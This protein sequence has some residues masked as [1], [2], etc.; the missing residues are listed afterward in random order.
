MSDNLS[1]YSSGKYEEGML[2]T[3]PFYEA[4]Y[5]ETTSLIGYLKPHVES[6]LDTGCG[7]GSLIARAY[8]LFRDTNFL[9]A[10]PS[11]EM[12]NKAQQTLSVIPASQL[13]IIGSI[14]TESLPELSSNNPQVITA[15]LAHHYFNKEERKTATDRC[16]EL[17]ETQGVYITFE[18][19]YP[20]TEEGKEIGL[21]RWK[22]FQKSQGKTENEANNHIGRYN[23]SFFPVT[24]EEHLQILKEAGFRVVELFWFSN[25]QA[26][27]YAIK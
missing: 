15:I 20:S 12:L 1:P 16:F 9:L 10:D 2:K 24:I 26:G 8:P 18:N 6:W 17:L 19:I 25:M 13:E 7:T 27:F 22:E 11:E 3:M 23:K 4:I 5:S 21:G 14:G